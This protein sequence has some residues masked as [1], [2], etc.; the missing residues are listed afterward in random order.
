LK[1]SPHV[2]V[3]STRPAAAAGE[4]NTWMEKPHKAYDQVLRSIRD[5]GVAFDRVVRR[6][7]QVRNRRLKEEARLER[8]KLK[9]K[10]SSRA[11]TARERSLNT[12]ALA[13]TLDISSRAAVARERS[14]ANGA[15][16]IIARPGGRPH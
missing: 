2:G 12:G 6:I 3:V 16:D 15:I 13:G 5:A 1:R 14:Q 7:E 10:P 4:K 8:M 11:M 9:V